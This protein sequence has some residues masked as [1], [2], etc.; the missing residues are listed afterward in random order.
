MSGGEVAVALDVGGTGMKCALVGADG[1]VRHSERHPTDA[2]R[3]PD[4]V[5]E[6]IL[7]VADG[8]AAKA[9]ADGLTPTA[10]GIVVPGVVDEAR[11]VALWSANVGF[12][13]VPLRELASRRL[14]LPTALGHDVRA[15]GLAEARLGA[16]RNA[17]HVLFVAIGTGIAAAHVVAGAAATG[18][19]GAAGELGHIL[20]RPDGPV[21][22]CGRPGCLEAIASASAVAH[23]YAE[24]AATATGTATGTG[25]TSDDGS[26]ARPDPGRTMV[27][28]AEVAARAAAG[29]QL[30]TRVWREAVEALAD[31]LATGQA[32]FDVE[33]IV[34]GGGLAQAGAGLFDPLRAALRDRLTF[35]REPR[36]VPAALGDEAG[37]LGAALLALDQL[38]KR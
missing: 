14:G 9:R 22:G 13:D 6:T 11:G 32:L 33:T 30:A 38:E 35:H 37:C 7:T 4:A 34:L 16:G 27:S 19:H 8:L 12:R 18:A 10:L 28:A 20:V 24:L 36:L 3:G 23:R 5:V 26:A 21:C 2:G 17:G 25:I 1:A 29:E 15:G 31:G